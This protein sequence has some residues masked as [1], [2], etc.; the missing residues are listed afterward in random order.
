MKLSRQFI[1]LGIVTMAGR[2]MGL[3]RDVLIVQMIGFHHKLDVYNSAI[4]LPGVV[5]N[6]LVAV[7]VSVLMPRMVRAEENSREQLRDLVSEN[8]FRAFLLG[9]AVVAL[10]IPLSPFLVS[11]VLPGWDAGKQHQTSIC[12]AICLLSIPLSLYNNVLM[13]SLFSIGKY[14]AGG[15]SQV[16]IAIGMCAAIVGIPRHF[17]SAEALS[18]AYVVTTAL[19]SI[20][21]I[22]FAFRE[23][24]LAKP[25]LTHL[26]LKKD[27]DSINMAY[28]SVAL[29]AMP[30]MDQT[31]GSRLGEAAVS[32]IMYGLRV[33][34]VVYGLM[35]TTASA[36]L[37]RHYSQTKVQDRLSK[38]RA[39]WKDLGAAMV[40][41]LPLTI[42][43]GLLSDPICHL[44]Y[45]RRAGSE[46]AVR[47]IISVQQVYVWSIPAMAVMII[48]NQALKGRGSY[49]A[50]LWTSV[51]LVAAKA[52]CLFVFF[53]PVFTSLPASVMIA[54]Y[55]N[56][57]SKL[58]ACHKAGIKLY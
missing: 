38:P 8:S 26:K 4:N 3:I 5:F 29:Q 55:T 47:L 48:T 27:K 45:N 23:G 35:N 33:P 36:V 31:F 37:G 34:D 51:I 40:V 15:V 32:I 41:T 11:K 20:W 12:F 57:V 16:V 24:M 6:I 25:K 52:S 13:T 1:E 43:L 10:V 56:A 53:P 39:F 19:G 2:L 49:A 21:L 7:Q 58:F 42:V 18:V 54:Y 46:S 30:L 17:L 28:A 44:L 22:Y 9:L 14:V 50:M